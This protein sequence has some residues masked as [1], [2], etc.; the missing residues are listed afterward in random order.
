MTIEDLIKEQIEQLNIKELVQNE[1]R[2]LVSDDVKREITKVTKE[3]VQRI[4]RTEV[5][6]QMSK[7]V[8]TDDGWGKKES[9]N[10]FEEMFKKHFAE[11]L[12]SK[13]EI[14]NIVKKHITDETKR[15]VDAKTS[16][17]VKLLKSQL[18]E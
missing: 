12:N 3:E 11:A 16:D 4:I 14:Q 5:E 1:I 6:I 15:L 13:Y 2:R 10:S 8:K 18:T 17:I 9:Y 7:G